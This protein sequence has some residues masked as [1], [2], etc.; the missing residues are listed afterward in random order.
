[1]I[2][3]I[4]LN[5]REIVEVF[6][7]IPRYIVHPD[8]PRGRLVQPVVVG[9][10]GGGDLTY[11]DQGMATEG[12]ARFKVVGVKRASVPAGKRIDGRPSYTFNQRGEVIETVVLMTVPAPAEEYDSEAE[13]EQLKARITALEAL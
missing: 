8:N 5:P 6:T 11:D 1:M 9:W 7:S 12:E 10:K 13:I 4:S 3:L 2:A